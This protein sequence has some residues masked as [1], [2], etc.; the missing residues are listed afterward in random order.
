MVATTVVAISVLFIAN[1]PVVDRNPISLAM[2]RF[3]RGWRDQR[4]VGRGLW[5]RKGE[6]VNGVRSCQLRLAANIPELQKADP[7]LGSVSA[8]GF[9]ATLG[10]SHY[11]GP[12]YLQVLPLRIR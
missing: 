1:P 7:V 9:D 2:L 10:N 6:L 8:I 12:T 3:A 11:P 5:V 4:R